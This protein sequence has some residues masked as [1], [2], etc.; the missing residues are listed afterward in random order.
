MMMIEGIEYRNFVKYLKEQINES[1]HNEVNGI[2]VFFDYYLDYPPK[3]LEDDGSDFFREEIDRL[4]QSQIFYMEKILIK[5]EFTW[6]KI[7]GDKWKLNSSNLEHN[8]DDKTELFRRLEI[9]E[10][11]LFNLS[12]QEVDEKIRKR[13]VIFYNQ[14]VGKY[15]SDSEKLIIVKLIVDSHLYAISDSED[16]IDYISIAGD[17]AK[18]LGKIGSYKYYEKV[19]KYYRNKY[20]HE[21][22]AKNFRLAIDAATLCNE[23][24][25]IIL[26]LTKNM[27]IQYELCG[28]ED[29]A[30]KAFIGENNLKAQLDGS[31]KVRF[32]LATLRVLSDYCQNPKKVAL[33]AFLLILL[34]ALVYGFSGITPSGSCE[35][36]FFSSGVS[37]F[38]V[39]FDSLYFSVVTFT[40]LGYGDF[41]PSNDL[42]R[43]IANIESLGGLF[44]TSLF[45]VSIVR[46]YGR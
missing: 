27:R 19:G 32:V 16:Y 15:G 24:K 45:L 1:T 46:K 2:E 5:E 13:L 38:R 23:D 42:S 14:K 26:S 37:A 4:V 8:D 11:A 31:I 39:L 35:Q 9:E 40:T 6:L 3:G 30:A 17:I 34:S 12:V 10:E 44:F 29:E 33:W 25:D 36:T 41:S 22:S 28:D 7:E 21:E 43:F 20:E 18:Q